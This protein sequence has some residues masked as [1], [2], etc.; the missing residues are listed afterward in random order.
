MAGHR[1]KIGC[2]LLVGTSLANCGGSVERAP[3]DPAAQ[4]GSGTASPGFIGTAGV[5]G[6]YGG[7]V[8]VGGGPV[9]VGGDSWGFVG[10]GGCSNWC[11][12]PGIEGEYNAWGGA[13]GVDYNAGGVSGD[14]AIP[15]A[16]AAGNPVG[17]EGGGSAAGSGGAL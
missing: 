14:S 11:G 1:L 12:D 2:V 4:G 8:G 5:P 16:G 13:A 7:P 17:G 6:N 3:D 15:Y 10:E 9:G